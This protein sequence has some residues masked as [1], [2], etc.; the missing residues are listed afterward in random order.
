LLPISSYRLALVSLLFITI[1]VLAMP[2]KSISNGRKA[3]YG[4]ERFQGSVGA[5]MDWQP[6]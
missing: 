6:M 5:K 3:N 1:K 2:M 4:N